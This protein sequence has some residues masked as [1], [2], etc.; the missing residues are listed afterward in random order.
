MAD[1]KI[2]ELTALTGANVATDDQLVIVDTS[3]ALTKNITI[4]EFKNALDTATGFV[5]ITGDTM[6]GDLSMG[7]NVKAIFGAGSD[8]SIYHD[9]SNS[10]I[11]E[12]GT[13]NL[14]VAGSNEVKIRP[15]PLGSNLAVFKSGSV[16]LYASGTKR[17]ET[18]STGIDVTGTI[19]GDDI[20]LSDAG[21]P[22]I[23]LTDTTN[24]LTTI[25]QSGNS[26]G[27]VGTTTDHDL[28]IQRNGSD[29][30]DVLSTGVDVTGT[31]TADGLT[32]DGTDGSIDFGTG[33][34]ITIDGGAVA[35][36]PRL[37]FDQDNLTGGL[38]FIEADRGSRA[39]EFV[40]ASTNRIQ[41]AEGGNISFYEDTGTT[42]KF[43]WDASAESLGIGTSSPS[44]TLHIEGTTASSGDA[45][46][47]VI[48]ADDTS[49]A[50]GVGGGIVFR[51]K[52]N[53]AG[54]FTNMSSIQG[55]KEN[56]TDGNF[57]GALVFTTRSHGAANA[58]A[59]RID[60]SGNLLVGKTSSDTNAVGVQLG[61]TGYGSFCRDANKV[62]IFNRK[63]NN[64]TILDFKKDGTSVGSIGVYE[65]DRLYIA[66]QS[67]GL[68]FD[69]TI[70][71]PCNNTGANTD[72]VVSLG[73]GGSRFRDLFLSGGVYLGGTG[74]ANHLDDYEEGTWTPVVSGSGTAGTYTTTI[75]YAKYTKVGK[76][77]TVSAYLGNITESSAGS[78][79]VQ[80][81]GLPFTK[82][83]GHY[84]AGTAWVSQWDYPSTVRSFAL[85]P[86]TYSGTS[87]TFY[88]HLGH[89]N[90]SASNLLLSEIVSGL[91]DIGITAT[92]F[93][94]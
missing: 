41:I 38:Y 23:T 62:G 79:Y 61:A 28:R 4:D 49:F 70:I 26:T 27:I 45:R 84:F 72:D 31:V 37:Y 54:S 51:A 3:A 47:N 76:V 73:G 44:Q 14:I 12:A 34:A 11:E 85:E 33:S 6:T 65:S 57:A 21:T 75:T 5:R 43:F 20:I 36:N 64:G 8:L 81:T 55:I 56:G 29:I 13:G 48:I 30:I 74:S 19:T 59:M 89:D 10:F 91:S 7:D 86:T 22:S 39:M 18:T 94:T 78:G 83:S 50:A 87:T 2:S 60:S 80:I 46:S 82:E 93:A 68:Q 35:T 88:I 32:V 15:T 16:D 40:T 17:L 24:T 71:R 90:A 42:P 67:N 92:Y 1:K 58:E 9:G 53:T 25:I 66:D 69:Q 63:T 52:Y 77:V